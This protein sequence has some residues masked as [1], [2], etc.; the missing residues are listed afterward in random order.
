MQ[1]KRQNKYLR[2]HSAEILPLHYACL[3]RSYLSQTII[4]T[5]KETIT[6]NKMDTN[7]A[8]QLE[9]KYSTIGRDTHSVVPTLTDS[10]NIQALQCAEKIRAKLLKHLREGKANYAGNLMV[11]NQIVA[12]HLGAANQNPSSRLCVAS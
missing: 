2:S 10:E 8:V 1:P 9:N 11:V 6:T 5:F 7:R 4:P 3:T 12:E